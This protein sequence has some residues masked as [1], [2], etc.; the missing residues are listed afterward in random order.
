MRTLSKSWTAII[1]GD[2]IHFDPQP[3]NSNVLSLDFYVQHDRCSVKGVMM[4]SLNATRAEIE[5][6]FR[7]DDTVDLDDI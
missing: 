2:T 5:A 3:V 1:G 4:A 7:T 6:R